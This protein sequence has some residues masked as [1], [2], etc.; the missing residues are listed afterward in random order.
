M[1]HRRRKK[2]RIVLTRVVV[3]AAALITVA[4]AALVIELHGRP[5][6]GHAAA[7]PA[8]AAHPKPR[9]FLG[10][11]TPGVP[12]SYAGVQA[13]T[14]AT[15]VRPGVVVYYSG[16]MEPFQVR[17]AEMAARHHAVPLVQID[18]TGISLTAIAAGRTT[19]T[20]APTPTRCGPSAAG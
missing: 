13:F 9:A 2:T 5:T 3:I 8:A 7:P 11:Y 10:V 20:C 4:A 14:A 15:G 6:A 18:P 12:Q 1:S 16:W 17:F 19:P